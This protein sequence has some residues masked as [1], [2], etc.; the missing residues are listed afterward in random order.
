ME[1]T[2]VPLLMRLSYILGRGL[3]KLESDIGMKCFQ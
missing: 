2:D 1:K 3:H